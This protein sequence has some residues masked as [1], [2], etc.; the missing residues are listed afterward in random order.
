MRRSVRSYQAHPP[1]LAANQPS[2]QSR[3][4][5]NP[6]CMH[7]HQAAP[8]MPSLMRAWLSPTGILLCV[9]K[10]FSDY[11]GWAPS[12]LAGRPLASVCTEP[13]ELE[14]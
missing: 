7:A 4:A 8:A 14:R 10:S 9:D 5:R 2:N 6:A 12:E 13:A 3:R 11:V 1:P